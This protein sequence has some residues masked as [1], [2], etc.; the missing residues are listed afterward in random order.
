MYWMALAGAQELFSM[1]AQYL[2]AIGLKETGV[3]S[4]EPTAPRMSNLEGMYGAFELESILAVSRMLV[5]PQYY[6]HYKEALDST[7]Q[8]PFDDTSLFV[9]FTGSTFS[10]IMNKIFGAEESSPNGA[11]MVNS[12]I[13]SGLLI[14]QYYDMI[15]AS[16]DYCGLRAYSS[17][18]AD[19]YLG[20][21]AIAGH[22]NLGLN[23]G[24]PSALKT[25]AVLSDPNGCDSIPQ[26]NSAYVPTVRN[27]LEALVI[28]QKRWAQGEPSV[29][30][31][32]KTITLE[33]VQTFFW[34]NGG[35]WD[36]P[37][38]NGL[39]WHFDLS[40]QERNNLWDDVSQTFNTLASHWGNNTI[41][42]RYDWL[43]LLRVAKKQLNQRRAFPMGEEVDRYI[44][45]HSSTQCDQTIPNDTIW[46][47]LKLEAS[48]F[49]E[50]RVTANFQ[51]ES[52]DIRYLD[53]SLDNGQNWQSLEP[54]SH[55]IADNDYHF[56]IDSNTLSQIDSVVWV[57][58]ADTCKNEVAQK[59]RISDTPVSMIT[60]KSQ[61]V[62]QAFIEGEHAMI[63]D[64]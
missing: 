29:R 44:A 30:V 24:A 37:G 5:Y 18:A 13:M 46:P 43:T 45:R 21:C 62:S 11:E 22:Y 16:T 14:Y 33:N 2:M 61:L 57:R 50:L 3:G 8:Q 10:E 47:F 38:E 39:M 17:E 35:S 53:Y 1:D 25:Q 55:K 60:P 63:F 28:D 54:Q 7:F 27:T 12:A 32:N 15:A 31:V 58:A 4:T 34:G 19:Q 40:Y 49:K 52:T 42:F 26:G 36:Q 48:L 51:D 56:T 59:I 6:P 64:A 20:L 23:G 41:S 9:A